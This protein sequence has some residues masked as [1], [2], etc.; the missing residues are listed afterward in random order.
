MNALNLLILYI[1][2]INNLV[3]LFDIISFDIFIV[4]S[5]AIKQVQKNNTK[6]SLIRTQSH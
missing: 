6:P 4:M 3:L 2:K 5:E 1:Y